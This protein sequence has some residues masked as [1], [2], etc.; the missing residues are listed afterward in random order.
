[1]FGRITKILPRAGRGFVVTESGDEVLFSSYALDNVD[2]HQLEEGR[3]VEFEL[4]ELEMGRA[5]IARL[6]PERGVLV[7]L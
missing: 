7:Q 1:M 4:Y 3:S 6:H 2:I 5:A